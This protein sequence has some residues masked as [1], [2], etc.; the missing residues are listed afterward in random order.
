MLLDVWIR[1]SCTI[2]NLTEAAGS[3]FVRMKVVGLPHACQLPDYGNHKD[4]KQHTN[5]TKENKV[6]LRVQ[7]FVG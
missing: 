1:K 4:G 7:Y 3:K 6:F 2:K 5:G